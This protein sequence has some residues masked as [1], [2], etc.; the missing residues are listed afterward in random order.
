MI[1]A[2]LMLLTAAVGNAAG[3]ARDRMETY[4]YGTLDDLAVGKA[5][6]CI[7]GFLLERQHKCPADKSVQ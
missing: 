3:A 7:Y 4:F 6:T 2:R 1:G 5:D